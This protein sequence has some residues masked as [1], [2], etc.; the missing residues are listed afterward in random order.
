MQL[1]ERGIRRRLAPMLGGDQRRIELALSLLFTL[2]GTPVLWYGDEIGMGDDLDLPERNSVRTPMQWAAAPNGG[3]S[4]APAARLIRPVLADRTYGYKER[5]VAAQ[6]RDP[7]SLLNSVEKMIRIRKEHEEFGSG[8]WQVVDADVPSVFATRSAA[9]K[10]VAFG[11]QNLSPR[12]CEAT[13][14]LPSEEAAALYEILA[15]RAYPPPAK[16]TGCIQLEGYGYRW[17]GCGALGG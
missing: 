3:F 15:D 10:L 8:S 13:L 16:R 11:V 4:T 7:H 12:P 1:Y 5:N 17:F 6:Q 9:G 2:P 14:D